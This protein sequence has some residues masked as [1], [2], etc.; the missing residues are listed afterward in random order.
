[1]SGP[2]ALH[3]IE[4]RVEQILREL[5]DAQVAGTAVAADQ[6]FFK[7]QLDGLERPQAALAL[8]LEHFPML[9]SVRRL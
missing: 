3:G 6:A 7:S 4:E 2:I 9:V 1:M 5:H 8:T